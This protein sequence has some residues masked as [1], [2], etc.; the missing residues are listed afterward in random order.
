[1]IRAASYNDKASFFGGYLMDVVFH[2]A[3]NFLSVSLVIGTIVD[4]L[5]ELRLQEERKSKSLGTRCFMCDLERGW[6]DRKANGF[7]AHI[8]GEHC[9][10][11]YLEFVYGLRSRSRNS[12]SG[13]EQAVVDQLLKQTIEWLPNSRAVVL[14]KIG[15]Y[16]ERHQQ[17]D[18]LLENLIQLDRTLDTFE[19]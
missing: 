5:A 15:L 3:V 19:D 11:S 18:E 6:F 8:R 12:Y 2:M 1:M 10:W 13:I 14:E 9:L 4:S 16:T 17:M 7:E